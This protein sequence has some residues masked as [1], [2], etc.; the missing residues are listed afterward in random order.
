MLATT[1]T[2]VLPTLTEELFDKNPFVLTLIV[3]I[4]NCVTIATLLEAT[5]S[6]KFPLLA[7]RCHLFKSAPSKDA[8]VLLPGKIPPT[9]SA[10]LKV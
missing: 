10:L 1:F 9:P 2:D 3:L 8:D 7:Y 4:V 6:E 5:V